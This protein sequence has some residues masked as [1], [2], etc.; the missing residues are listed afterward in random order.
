MG[1]EGKEGGSQSLGRR[2]PC[3]AVTSRPNS[4]CLLLQHA[5]LCPPFCHS[6]SWSTLSRWDEPARRLSRFGLGVRPD[7]G[8]SNG[9]LRVSVCWCGPV[10]VWPGTSGWSGCPLSCSC[11]RVHCPRV[12]VWS[13]ARCHHA[14]LAVRVCRHLTAAAAGHHHHHLLLARLHC[15]CGQASWRCRLLAHPGRHPRHRRRH[16]RA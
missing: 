13:A 12:S 5:P 6:G 14:R 9:W 1:R 15:A 3:S 8:W 11:V 10:C 2:L 4:W 7:A 16:R